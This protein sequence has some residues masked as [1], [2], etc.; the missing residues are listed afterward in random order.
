MQALP[1]PPP[2]CD[3]GALLNELITNKLLV[4]SEL[5]EAGDLNGAR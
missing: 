4:P 3:T 5:T 2:V 1:L